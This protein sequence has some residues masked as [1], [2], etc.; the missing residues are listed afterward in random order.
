MRNNG[1]FLI[2]LQ[3]IHSLCFSLLGIITNLRTNVCLLLHCAAHSEVIGKTKNC[4]LS[5][6]FK[7]LSVVGWWPKNKV[8]TPVHFSCFT[9]FHLQLLNTWKR[10]LCQHVSIANAGRLKDVDPNWITLPAQCN[11]IFAFS[12]EL[13]PRVLWKSI[14]H[15]TAAQDQVS[16]NYT[17]SYKI[18]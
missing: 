1:V 18:F 4:R 8:A 10:F 3:F 2:L 14:W 16:Y 12:E 17:D 15:H 5:D 7:M 6:I 9:Y 13:I 11:G